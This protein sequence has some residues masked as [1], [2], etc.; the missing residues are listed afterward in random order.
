MRVDR[1]AVFYEFATFRHHGEVIVD[2]LSHLDWLPIKVVVIGLSDDC[3]I[4]VA[5]NQMVRRICD[6][7]IVEC[8][9]LVL[10]LRGIHVRKA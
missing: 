3:L 2:L 7:L 5:F 6:L 1:L 4:R 9:K 8:E 10:L